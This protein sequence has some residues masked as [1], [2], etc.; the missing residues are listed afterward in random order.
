MLETFFVENINQVKKD[1]IMSYSNQ[2]KRYILKNAIILD[3]LLLEK[4]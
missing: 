1:K 4:N 3:K 2:F